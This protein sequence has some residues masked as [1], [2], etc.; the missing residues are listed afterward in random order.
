M[1]FANHWQKKAA[2]SKV[3]CA[4]HLANYSLIKVLL[5]KVFST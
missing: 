2:H 4:L 1:E 3:P 5:Y